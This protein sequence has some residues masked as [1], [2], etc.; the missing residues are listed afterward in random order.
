MAK[1]TT[2]VGIGGCGPLQFAYYYMYISSVDSSPSGVGHEDL[3]RLATSTFGSMPEGDSV[4]VAQAD[5]VGGM[6]EFD[7]ERTLHDAIHDQP[8]ILDM[9][10]PILFDLDKTR[11]PLVVAGTEFSRIP[12]V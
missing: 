9:R 12:S 7:V 10:N 1:R 3:V 6:L 11:G 5:F 2:L 8:K 4:T